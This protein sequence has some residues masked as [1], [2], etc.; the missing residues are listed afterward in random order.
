MQVQRLQGDV[1]RLQ[2]RVRGLE[3]EAKGLESQVS[4]LG[5]EVK[6]ERKRAED[7]HDA[8]VKGQQVSSKSYWLTHSGMTG[9]GP[10]GLELQLCKS[11]VA[12]LAA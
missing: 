6:V 10:I 8:L 3:G 1:Q 2:K 4:N 7:A 12:R 5:D 9:K 11:G